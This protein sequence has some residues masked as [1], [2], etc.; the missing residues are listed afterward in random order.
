MPKTN[1][2]NIN[3]F[4]EQFKMCENA[5]RRVFGEDCNFKWY[6]EKIS[7]EA[8]EIAQK[9]YVCRVLRNY[10][11]HNPHANEFI[12]IS[13]KTIAFLQSLELQ[14]LGLQQTCKDKMKKIRNPLTSKNK[15]IDIVAYLQ[16]M[17]YVP[18]LDDNKKII[19]LFTDDVLRKVV[20]QNISTKK[21][22]GTLLLIPINKIKYYKPIDCYT[23]VVQEMKNNH[24]S[25]AIITDDGTK[26]GK[27]MG[28]I[29]I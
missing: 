14:I 20:L 1:T 19:G 27:F 26:N 22:I 6:E 4:L 25:F 28:Y 15:I 13:S 21:S 23:D 12:D 29:I 17:P 16:Q 3:I 2:N 7:E 24:S 18:I 9:M 5:I 11:S 10:I 8:G